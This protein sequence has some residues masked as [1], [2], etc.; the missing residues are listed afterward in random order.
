MRFNRC[1]QFR[2]N[3]FHNQQIYNNNL[4]SFNHATKKINTSLFEDKKIYQYYPVFR[5]IAIFLLLIDV[6]LF[7]LCCIVSKP[8]L[9]SWSLVTIVF[10]Q[11][12]LIIPKAWYYW[13]CFKQRYYR[14]NQ[15]NYKILNL[16]GFF[17]AAYMITFIAM[18]DCWT[19][20]VYKR[21]ILDILI[22][23]IFKGVDESLVETAIA[24]NSNINLFYTKIVVSVK[25][26][27]LFMLFIHIFVQ[28]IHKRNVFTDLKKFTPHIKGQTSYALSWTNSLRKL[29]SY[30][31]ANSIPNHNDNHSNNRQ[32]GNLL[33]KVNMSIIIASDDDS[34]SYDNSNDSAESV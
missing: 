10:S 12:L 17:Y 14:S 20:I 13:F 30:N 24:T 22:S 34:T 25:L 33:N 19:F 18:F 27:C 32:K 8:M 15:W 2:Q 29:L 9:S 3:D 1:F 31:S 28:Y 7:I 21:S 6:V 16:W 5:I 23:V 26:I 11:T 4:F